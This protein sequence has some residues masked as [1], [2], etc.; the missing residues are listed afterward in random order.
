MNDTSKK[1][2][3]RLRND[4]ILIGA[5]VFAA[6]IFLGIFL[7]KSEGGDWAV[8]TVDDREIARYSLFEEGEYSIVSGENDEY[9]NELVIKDGKAFVTE[10]NCPDG[11]CV[12]HRAISRTGETIVCL[13]HKLVIH[14]ETDNDSEIDMVS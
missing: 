14:I 8:V 2:K 5:F 12:S 4:I 7:L 6:L 1:T 3:G 9:I 13:P 11:I 10:A